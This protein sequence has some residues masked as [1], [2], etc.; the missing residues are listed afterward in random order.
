MKVFNSAALKVC[1]GQQFDINYEAESWIS[2]EE[3]IQMIRLKT[4]VLIAAALQM[5]AILG[6]ADEADQVNLYQFGLNLGLAFQLQDDYL[7]TFGDQSVFGKRIGNDILTNK[8]T[9]LLVK[10]L[11]LS[12]GAE[13]EKLL[14]LMISKNYDETE[15]IK[16]VTEIYEHL[17]IGDL[18]KRKIKSFHQNS[19]DHLALVKVQDNRKVLLMQ[20]AKRLITRDK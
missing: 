12:K 10:A 15:K 2:E 7:D 18:T 19:M 5:G 8:K 13:K 17:F 9:Y 4:S 6:D 20:L 14:Q 3:Y 1:E 11:E 16:Q